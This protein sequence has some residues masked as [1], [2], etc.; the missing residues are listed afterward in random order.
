MVD[1]RELQIFVNQLSLVGKLATKNLGG[2]YL[3]AE[4]NEIEPLEI[5]RS[6]DRLVVEEAI[7]DH[8]KIVLHDLVDLGQ[9]DRV[10][11]NFNR[12][13]Y[14][15]FTLDELCTFDQ[16]PVLVKGLIQEFLVVFHEISID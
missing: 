16:T 13:T 2:T 12:I 3:F 9:L 5:W 6:R 7:F 1:L 10:N 14:L 15:I 8:K 11:L 4:S